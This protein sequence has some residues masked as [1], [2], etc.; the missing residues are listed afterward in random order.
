MILFFLAS[1]VISLEVCNHP[2]YCQGEILNAIQTMSIYKDSKTFVDMPMKYELQQVL[3]N[4]KS[5]NP[6]DKQQVVDFIEVNF[7]PA[8]SDSVF[9]VPSDWKQNPKFIDN[10]S[11]LKLK[12]WAQEINK[13]WLGLSKR[14]TYDESKSS[15]I[16]CPHPFFVPGGRFREFYYW[17]TLWVVE[18]LL[19]SEMVDSAIKMQQN[20]LH[21]IETIGYI[22]NGA[23]IY[24]KGRSQPMVTPLI[25][26]KIYDYLL[27]S[28]QKQR[29][30]QLLQD[31]FDLLE[32]EFQFFYNERTHLSY[33]IFENAKLD[34]RIFYYSSATDYPRPE[35]YKE[36][37]K[38]AQKSKDKQQKYKDIAAGAESGWDFSSRWFKSPNSFESIS[39]T[40]VIPVDLNVLMILNMRILS[41]FAKI[42]GHGQKYSYY[43]LQAQ[44]NEELLNSNFFN[45]TQWFDYLVTEKKLKVDYY[46]SNFFPL[47][48]GEAKNQ[49]IIEELTKYVNQFEGGLPT[50]LFETKQQW[51][52]PNSWPP[53]NQFVIEGLILNKQQDLAFQLSQKWINNAYCSYEKSL[54]TYGEGYMFEK[55]DAT[56]IGNQGGGGEYEVQSGFGWTNGVAIWILQKFGDKLLLP[57]C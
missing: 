11:E 7:N 37:I 35:A 45:Q 20:F 31:S 13:L 10:I 36:D 55:Y 33:K 12:T 40:N 17:D 49:K 22:P 5:V 19:G 2:I 25:T 54:K 23:R 28:N 53:L 50:S 24:Y 16:S 8:G 26:E 34:S 52:Y 44:S 48:L 43:Q 42:L 38:L 21:L 32:R 30:L 56:K 47:L 14:F 51:D 1:I 9:S 39:T 15:Y 57:N 4:W 41:R 18:G 3:V 29:A 46:P 27:Q 6:K